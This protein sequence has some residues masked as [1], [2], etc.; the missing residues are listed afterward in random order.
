MKSNVLLLVCFACT[1]HAG[2]HTKKT[3]A[4]HVASI[5]VFKNGLAVVRRTVEVPGNGTYRVLDV[6]QPI[7]GTFWIESSARVL[8]KVSMRNMD[9]PGNPN[10]MS[11]VELFYG[12]DVTLHLNSNASA[13]AQG[14]TIKGKLLR[15][16]KD[17]SKKKTWNR[18]YQQ[19]GRYDY[20]GNFIPSYTSQAN[21]NTT[22]GQSFLTI[23][24]ARGIARLPQSLVKYIEADGQHTTIQASRPVLEFKVTKTQNR[25]TIIA[26]CYLAKGIAWAPSYK[27]DLES[28]S[29]LTIEQKAVIKNEFGGLRNTEIRLISG[30]PNVAFSHVK[31]PLSLNSQW[32]TFFSQLNQ[33]LRPSQGA[34]VTSQ[35][36]VV[37]NARRTEVAPA[38]STLNM[39]EGSGK[40]VDMYY[41]S[42]GKF[43]LAEGESMAF[44]VDR[45]A[46]S[47]DR[48]IEWSV[49][50]GWDEHGR[51][52]QAH[53]RRTNPEKY[54][55]QLWDAVRFNNPFGFPMTTAA[56]SLYQGQKFL[57]QNMSYWVNPGAQTM[58][59]I[60]KAL[61]IA[62]K[63]SE[64]EIDSKRKVVR[65][66][67]SNYQKTK[68]KGNLF[69]KNHRSKSVR[70][71]I[72]RQFYGDLLQAEGEPR[73]ELNSSGVYSVNELNDLTWEVTLKAGETKTLAYSFE[74]L[75]S[76]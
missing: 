12:K 67:S 48:I 45:K 11:V 33:Q 16:D 17:N 62:A 66:G 23:R 24:T 52:I 49:P 69:M 56:A 65:I 30:F 37:T 41:H 59:R 50:S 46:A 39:S 29:R 21:A 61:S 4:T 72:H 3:V 28:K 57:G 32:S 13:N 25:P 55:D 31:S 38:V 71:L 8:T 7:H 2:P 20:W 40:G 19:Q 54:R 70:L 75:A 43:D 1:A 35:M 63:S 15:F 18:E 73:C 5:G 6:P 58:Q 74:F 26:I 64:N 53:V 9:E 22:K 42:A 51:W 10:T 76:I 36:A 60:T 47:Y 34:S 44:S 14:E 68:I 27:I